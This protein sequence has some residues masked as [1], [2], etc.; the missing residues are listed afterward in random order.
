MKRVRGPDDQLCG[1][2]W[3][4]DELHRTRLVDYANVLSFFALMAR[5]EKDAAVRGERCE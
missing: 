4:W 5:G 2:F 1:T 3:S